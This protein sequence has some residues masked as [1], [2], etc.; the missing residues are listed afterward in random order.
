M[1]SKHSEST[2]KN[3]NTLSSPQIRQPRLQIVLHR[4]SLLLLPLLLFFF[5]RSLLPHRPNI[6]KSLPQHQIILIRHH[7]HQFVHL[8]HRRGTRRRRI[9]GL[10]HI[11]RFDVQIF[12]LF[13]EFVHGGGYFVNVH[14]GEAFVHSFDYGLHGFCDGVHSDGGFEAGGDG[15]YS[16]G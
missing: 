2:N 13:L 11:L 8:I 15:V 1:F 12:E 10:V 7:P 5:P 16:G 6:R 3:L 9:H 14:G 4:H